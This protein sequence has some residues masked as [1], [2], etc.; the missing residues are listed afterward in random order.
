ML[1]RV[2]AARWCRALPQV[3]GVREQMADFHQLRQPRGS[4]ILEIAKSGSH[5]LFRSRIIW[6]ASLERRDRRSSQPPQPAEVRGTTRKWSRR[7]CSASF[8]KLDTRRRRGG[9]SG[10]SSVGPGHQL[11]IHDPPSERPQTAICLHSLALLLWTR[12]YRRLFAFRSKQSEP[13]VLVTVNQRPRGYRGQIHT[14]NLLDIYPAVTP[15]VCVS[16]IAALVERHRGAMD[17]VVLRGLDETRQDLFRSLGFLRR[18]FDAPNGWLLDK[19]GFLPTRDWYMVP[20]D[21]DWLI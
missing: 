13:G 10:P 16:I 12:C 2:I 9:R 17:A 1:T 4:G 6:G 3:Y 5:S 8:Q 14:L 21:G 18:Q 7:A 19:S 11:P 20:A 15:E